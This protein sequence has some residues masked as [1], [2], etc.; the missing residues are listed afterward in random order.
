MKKLYISLFTLAGYLSYGQ[1]EA[2][3]DSIANSFNIHLSEVIINVDKPVFQ[4]KADKMIFSV[5]NSVL[6]EGSTVL[7]VLG[8][9]PGIVVS[10]DGELSLRGKKGVSVMLNGKLSSL[11]T[12][13]L[14]NLLRSTNSSVVKNIEII[15]NPSAKYDASGNAGIVNIVLKKYNIEGLKG[16]YYINGGRGRKNRLNTGM[17]LSYATEK[18]SL[19]GD[20]S[21]TFRGEEERKTYYQDFY[22]TSDPLLIDRSTK[23]RSITSEPLTSN[24]FKVGVDYT[25]SSKTSLGFLFDAK[26][27]RYEDKSKGSNLVY[28]PKNTLY[29]SI[30]TD[31]YND[32]HWYDYT[33][34]F[35]AAHKLN[36][37]GGKV[38]L[39]VEYETSK[40]RSM[41]TQLQENLYSQNGEILDDRKAK[42]PTHLKVF[43][44]KLDF[45]LPFNDNNALETGWKSIVKS[46]T[47][48]SIYETGKNGH[49][50]IDPEATNDYKY[51]EQIHSVYANYKLVIDKWQIQA[52][53][54]TEYTHRDIHQRTTNQRYKKDYTKLFPSASIKYE[55]ESAHGFYASYSKRINRPSHFDL[56][57]FRFYDD[58]FNYWQG[59]ANLKPEITH[60]SE[61]GYTW[62]KYLIATLYF[63]QT[64]D[65]MTQ[66]YNYI[67]NNTILVKTLENLSKSYH[68]GMTLTASVNPF[69]FW[70]MSNMFNLFNNKYEGNYNDND[71]NTKQIAF[72]LNSQNSFK[73]ASG[74]KA[75]AN[76]QYF[77]KSNIGLY[78]RDA[79]FDLSLGLSK[80]LLS[81][82][83]SIKLA[84]TDVLKTNNFRITG[85]NF[86]SKIRQ[87]YDLDS[88]IATLSFNYK[89]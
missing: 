46:N 18:V 31:N 70:S 50:N 11:S 76:A 1:T 29:Q 81:D 26:I 6:S 60:A 48:P 79:Y 69:E 44:A 10:Q 21:Y 53:L 83:A 59:N 20:Y 64:S 9:A 87:K 15:A 52:G 61:I 57:P 32:E 72:T 84:V 56:N 40:F 63:S 67:D 66:V 19:F 71:I 23:Q 51:K 89:F 16:S 35:T 14:A 3:L 36:E 73:I 27:G 34:N 7:E 85:E 38:D 86:N 88:R 74:I 62:S 4:Q 12:K 65:V 8:R 42:I 49:W 25:A 55:T 13:E 77:S 28:M 41:Q 75:E 30:A 39:D 47:N 45:T 2:Q 5:E 22:N 80:S 82:K 17:N 24:N 78:K 37:K 43:N 33:F 68:Y 54:R 58:P